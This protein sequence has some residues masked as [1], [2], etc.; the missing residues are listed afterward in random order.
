[1]GEWLYR[2]TK[3]LLV[4]IGKEAGW[5]PEPVWTSEERKYFFYTP[6][7]ETMVVPGELKQMTN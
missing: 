3:Q 7:I 5:T 6:G 1:V 2:S 4:T